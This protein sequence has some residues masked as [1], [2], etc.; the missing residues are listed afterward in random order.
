MIEKILIPIISVLVMGD[1]I[2]LQIRKLL[3]VKVKS[4]SP[5][6]FIAAIIFGYASFIF[7]MVLIGVLFENILNVVVYLHFSISMLFVLKRIFSAIINI[8]KISNVK[9]GNTFEEKIFIFLIIAISVSYLFYQ[10]IYYERG[11]DALHYYFPNAIY[12]FLNNGI[13][14]GV[15]PFSLYP[16]FKPPFNTLYITYSLYITN[17]SQYHTGANGHPWLLLMGTTLVTIEIT[18]KITNSD[19]L[20]YFTGFLFLVSPFSFFLIYEFAYYQDIPVM[21]FMISSFFFISKSEMDG[22]HYTLISSISSGLAILSKISGYTIIFL[23]FISFSINKN[24][25][26]KF[27]R[28]AIFFVII[29]FLI[30]NTA[31]DRYV[32]FSFIVLFFGTI[33]LYFLIKQKLTMVSLKSSII[34]YIIPLL[35]GGF[36][37]WFMNKTPEVTERL[38]ELYFTTEGIGIKSSF[39]SMPPYGIY[40]ENGMSISFLASVLYIF[41]GSMMG[42]F[43][44]IPKVFGMFL[45][46]TKVKNQTLFISLKIYFFTFLILYLAYFGNIS[47]RYLSPIHPVLIIFTSL[48]FSN[49]LKQLNF[50]GERPFTH[51]FFAAT[52]GLFYYP[53][54]PMQNL[55]LDVNIRLFEYHKNQI[56]LFLYVIVFSLLFL[57]VLYRFRNFSHK[58]Y[59]KFV[60]IFLLL[61]II[62]NS[63]PQLGVFVYT[64]FNIEEYNTIMNY[65]HRENYQELIRSVIDLDLEFND[66]VISVNTPGLEYFITRTVL[67]LMLINEYDEFKEILSL[68]INDTNDFINTHNVRVIIHL[69]EGHSYFTIFKEE[70]SETNFYTISNEPSIFYLVMENSEFS[71]Y[72][73]Q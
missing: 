44:L 30:Y 57:S 64:G 14:S 2:N 21:F 39:E 33:T 25:I 43:Y 51:F 49:I 48:G 47:G 36:W 34:F 11:W 19:Y 45:I 16:T 54:I 61:Y 56:A 60:S 10:V 24:Q 18:K 58:N 35:I 68:S 38:S 67:D 63:A 53:F 3:R 17:G 32:G 27:F 42:L 72:V 52:A 4:N 26:M 46:D 13:P 59:R 71:V 7:P 23:I 70:F 40:I 65:T 8:H 22:N 37:F 6:R 15:N 28:I 31:Y 5:E 41:T 62:A 1:V 66:L 69:N 20:S 50:G 55:F 29:T 73:K 9:V 12:F